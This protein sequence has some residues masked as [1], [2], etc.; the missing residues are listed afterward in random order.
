MKQNNESKILW[1]RLILFKKKSFLSL[2]CV[3]GHDINI[4]LLNYSFALND[5]WRNQKGYLFATHKYLFSYRQKENRWLPVR[6]CNSTWMPYVWWARLSAD[7][8]VGVKW[9]TPVS[10]SK[11]HYL[12]VER[13][14]IYG[15]TW[16][17]NEIAQPSVWIYR[18][19]DTPCKSYRRIQ[20]NQTASRAKIARWCH[21]ICNASLR[22][23]LHFYF[24]PTKKG[25]EIISMDN[26][27]VTIFTAELVNKIIMKTA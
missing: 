5:M 6:V 15:C 14:N 23:L 22:L 3:F 4:K 20:A 24:H 13:T 1:K 27:T 7:S 26:F 16:A 12:W 25:N 10:K 8:I 18:A 19:A 11:G 17:T 2:A 21:S 9:D